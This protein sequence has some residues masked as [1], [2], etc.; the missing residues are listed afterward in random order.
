MES[1]PLE[2][3]NEKKVFAIYHA[4]SSKTPTFYVVNGVCI[5]MHEPLGINKYTISSTFSPS[6]PLKKAAILGKFLYPSRNPSIKELQ[7][8]RNLYD[9]FR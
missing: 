6:N 1:P 2:I 4:N 9:V 3:L 5:Y 7:N 8:D